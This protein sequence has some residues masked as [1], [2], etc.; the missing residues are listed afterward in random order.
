M[1]AGILNLSQTVNSRLN[2][3]GIVDGK[4]KGVKEVA[5][6]LNP[7]FVAEDKLQEMGLKGSP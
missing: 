5:L 3:I 1:K 6:V 4:E 7:V 2:G